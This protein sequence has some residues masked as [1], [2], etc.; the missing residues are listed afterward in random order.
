MGRILEV[1]VANSNVCHLNVMAMIIAMTPVEVVAGMENAL[2]LVL[3][4][5][6][7]VSVM[8]GLDYQ[9]RSTV[10]GVAAHQALTVQMME[11]V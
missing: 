5:E 7:N 2:E 1:I 8:L 10:L 6:G 4:F 3:V 11:N 9:L